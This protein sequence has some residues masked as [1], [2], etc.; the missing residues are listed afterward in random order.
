[1]KTWT[2]TENKFLRKAYNNEPINK[3]AKALMRSKQSIRN[4]V[5]VLRKKGFAFDRVR[6]VKSVSQ[7]LQD[8]LEPINELDEATEEVDN[9]DKWNEF[10]DSANEAAE[11][12][13]QKKKFE[14]TNYFTKVSNKQLLRETKE[15]PEDETT[16]QK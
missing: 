15:A 16:T 4:H 3:I 14:S 1:M 6:D 9:V 10:I 7:Q 8:E 2:D 12:E 11:E 5:C 13:D